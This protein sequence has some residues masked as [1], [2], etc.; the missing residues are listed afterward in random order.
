VREHL[1]LDAARSGVRPSGGA[2]LPGIEGL[3]ALAACSI[4]GY[5]AWGLTPTHGK[6]LGLFDRFVPDLRFGVVLF[7]TLSGF[8]LYRP[9]A[10]AILQSREPPSLRRYFRNRALRILPAYWVILLACLALGSFL[11]WN[12]S[13]QLVGGRPLDAGLFVRS[14]FFLQD[15]SPHTLLA[16]IGPAWSLAVEAVFY[17]LLP[18]LVLLAARLARGSATRTR[19]RWAALTP[20][21]LLL[22]VGLTGKAAAAYLVPPRLPYA[23]YDQNWHSVLERSFWSQ[24][25]LFAFGIAVAVLSVDRAD[26]L[27]RLPR[28]WKSAAATFV[29]GSYVLTTATFHGEQL[30][31][32]P[33]NTLIAAACAVLLAL[34]VLEPAPAKPSRLVRLLEARPLVATGVISYSIFLWHEPLIRWLAA[35]GLLQEGSAGF[36]ANVA[37]AAVVTGI[38]SAATYV[39]VEAPALRLKFRRPAHEEAP[40]PAAQVEA[41]P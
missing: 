13:G 35:H 27:L 17:L 22:V 16:G 38:A 6:R 41:A 39:L 18:L 40:V 19:R 32:S 37:L 3:R 12:P 1:R 20:A 21:A 29:V 23:G 15:Y 36:L 5:H 10:A 4:L 9:F 7:F 26:G 28:W 33:A 24:A 8:L 31:Y 2:R 30:S 25:D 14:A 34:V 11:Y